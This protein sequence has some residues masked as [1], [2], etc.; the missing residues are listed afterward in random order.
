MVYTVTLNP[1]IDYIVKIK[2]FQKGEINRSLGEEVLPG[3]K[4]INVSIVLKELGID[5]IALGWISGFIGK[6][7]ERRV[8]EYGIQTDF[9]NV[10]NSVSRINI[11]VVEKGQETAINCVGPDVKKE[12]I[13]RLYGQIKK[14]GISSKKN[15]NYWMVLS[16]SSPKGVDSNVYEKICEILQDKDIRIVVDTTGEFLLN[17][18]KY[19]PFLIKPNKE[20]LEEIFE[21]KIN[22]KDEALEYARKLQEKGARNVLVTLGGEGAI[23][24]DENKQTYKTNSLN[25]GKRVS[26]V[27][28]GDSVIAGFIAGI[29]KFD[30]YKEA[31]SLSM[32]A[33]AATA[34]SMF[35]AKEEEINKLYLKEKI[36]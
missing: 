34:N 31:L 27:G 25:L 2:N 32:A 30:D 15:G 33:G 7:I 21:V 16:G 10:E 1:A 24:V 14:I 17:T 35:L 12:D 36:L 26:T 9:L 18:L 20:E 11:K 28:A 4:G 6:E 3:G 23:F 29:E 5:S 19:K 8:E 13:E 22:G